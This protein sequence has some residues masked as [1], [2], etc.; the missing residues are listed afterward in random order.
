M[1]TLTINEK[2]VMIDVVR[3]SGVWVFASECEGQHFHSAM[4][5][6]DGVEILLVKRSIVG[7]GMYSGDQDILK[8][9]HEEYKEK[10]RGVRTEPDSDSD[11][12]A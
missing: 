5:L 9:M 1:Y 10:A 4:N 7:V 3:E 12:T 11:A 6:R 2:L 8:A